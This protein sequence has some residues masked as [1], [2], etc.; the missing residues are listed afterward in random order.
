[1]LGITAGARLSGANDGP[2]SD[3][4]I[5]EAAPALQVVVHLAANRLQVYEAGK[6]TH[7]YV[8]S[9]GMPG[10]RTPVGA[11]HISHIVWNPW[12]IPPRSEWARGKKPTRP[13]PENPMGRVKMYFAPE[14][15]IHGTP[16]TGTL[17]QPVSHGCVRMYENDAIALAQ[18]VLRYGGSKVT[19][20]EIDQLLANPSRTVTMSVPSPIPLE[21]RAD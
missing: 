10:H 21:V 13:G 2:E 14:F 16:E 6:L 7:T 18:L 3:R 15:Y 4:R 11:Y 19:A 17:G 12:W 1:V 9:V 5:A 8:I 20:S